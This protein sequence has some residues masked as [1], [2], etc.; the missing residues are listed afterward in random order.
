MRKVHDS[1]KIVNEAGIETGKKFSWANSA[2][3][4]FAKVSV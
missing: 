4:I 2:K 3:Q 1:G